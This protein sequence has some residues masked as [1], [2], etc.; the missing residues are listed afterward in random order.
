MRQR[1]FLLPL[2]FLLLVLGG[3]VLQGHAQDRDNPQKRG[4]AALTID[5]AN[6]QFPPTISHVISATDSTSLI[7]GQLYIAGATDVQDEPVSGIT[8]QVGYGPAGTHP[9]SDD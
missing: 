2:I 6:L 3:H 4:K 7:Y 8:A 1:A 5:F 9:S